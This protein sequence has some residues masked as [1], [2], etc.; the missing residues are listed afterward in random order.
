MPEPLAKIADYVELV[1]ALRERAAALNLSFEKLDGL[2]GLHDGYSAH[3]LT[4][5]PQLS[6]R[7]LGKLSLG[8]VLGALGVELIMIEN[9][10]AMIKLSDRLARLG[11]RDEAQVR[12]KPFG[13]PKKWL[14]S[15]YFRSLGRRGGRARFD[16]MSQ[17]KSRCS[18]KPALELAGDAR[19]PINSQCWRRSLR[20][21]LAR[22]ASLADID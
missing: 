2:A 16:A 4:P 5:H 11:R 7:I 22:T 14:R 1:N 12:T 21:F 17:A 8:C 20:R 15:G 18:A 10:H 3:L 13:T 19:G 9:P 6:M